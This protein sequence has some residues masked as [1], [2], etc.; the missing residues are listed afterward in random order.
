MTQSYTLGTSGITVSALGL[1]TWQF[2]RGQ[3]M[4]GKY[5][6]TTSA[7]TEREIVRVSLEGGINWFD[8]AEVYGGGASERALAE[9]LIA[10][11]V[12][13]EQYRI[14][15]KWFPAFRFAR[16]VTRTF[17]TREAAL[18]GLG[19]DLHQIHQP[20]SFSSVEKQI[21]A[22]GRLQEQGSIRAVGVSNFSEKAMRRAHGALARA[23]MALA[24]NQ[25]RYSLLDR[26][27]E[28]NGVLDAARE[29]GITIIAYSPLSQGILT[30]RH[31][32]Q[33]GAAPLHGPRKWM[34][35]FKPEGLE[36]TRNLV[37]TLERI[38]HAHA[39]AHGGE[40][41]AAGNSPPV[42]AAQVALAWSVQMHGTSVVAI[43]G[44]SS[45]EQARSNAGA[46][47][48]R[49]SAEELQELDDAGREAERRLKKLS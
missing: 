21:L 7:S 6:T 42:T 41:D 47:A 35:R 22:M 30:G 16:S 8:T 45:V 44:A 12:P 9:A 15:D 36:A 32:R 11:N 33:A 48:I 10:L 43:P 13:R 40:G 25:M 20:F 23:G 38:A 24:T 19:I 3:G 17:P 28:R 49:L 31:H 18:Q 4:V 5:W 27:I 39:H 46:L 26:E 29:L 14:A 37:E 1:G 34:R 2:S